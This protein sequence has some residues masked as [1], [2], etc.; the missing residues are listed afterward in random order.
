MIGYL[1]KSDDNMTMSLKVDDS[2]LFKRYCRIW[3][4]ISSLLGIEFD[5][6]SVYDDTDSYMKT[7]VKSYDNKVNTNFQGKEVPKGDA[8]YKCFSLIMLNFIVKVGK[9]YYPQVFLK[10]CKYVKRKNK[11]VNYINDDIDITSSDKND[12]FYSESDSD[13]NN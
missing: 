8:S 13:S 12:E 11:M 6:D 4:A 5:S 2:K 9:K 7:K 1:K 3:R 10:E